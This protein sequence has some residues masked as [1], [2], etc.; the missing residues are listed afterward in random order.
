[1]GG[2]S[3]VHWLVLL[4]PLVAIAAVVWVLIRDRGKEVGAP[5]LAARPAPAAPA[6]EEPLPAIPPELE[7]RLWVLLRDRQTI[8]AIA[9]VK[10]ELGLDLR[11]SKQVVDDVERRLP[12]APG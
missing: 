11:R 1:M 5:P 2:V 8:Q 9:M 6:A 10:D 4:L 12:R 7:T 3:V